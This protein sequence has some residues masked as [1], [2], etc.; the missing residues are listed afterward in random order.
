MRAEN[1]EQFRE[2]SERSE[3]EPRMTITP[4]DG[5]FKLEIESDE[6]GVTAIYRAVA[7]QFL[8]AYGHVERR[9]DDSLDVKTSKEVKS[10][11]II[12]GIKHIAEMVR[13]ES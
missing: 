1:F 9:P 6:E 8:G 4:I 11:E 3:S 5:G 7:E 2:D 10:E 12:S 13:K